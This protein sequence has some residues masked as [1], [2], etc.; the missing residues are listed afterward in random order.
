MEAA[1]LNVE[2]ELK[3]QS[4][5]IRQMY[6]KLMTTLLR[7]GWRKLIYSNPSP[8][9]WLFMGYLVV[10]GI[11]YSKDR[12]IKWGMD[13]DPLCQLRKGVAET[14]NHLFFTCLVAAALWNKL[15]QWQGITRQCWD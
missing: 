11:V 5:S 1:G 13:M 10:N 3:V 8:P 9:K 6:L 15:L 4:F 12:L 7:V 2:D 14:I